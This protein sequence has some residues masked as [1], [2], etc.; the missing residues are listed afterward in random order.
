MDKKLWGGRFTEKTARSVE[1]FTSSISFDYR[2][3]HYDIQGSIAH[4]KML[5]KQKIIPADEAEKI[6]QALM[7]I[8]K[9]IEQSE[10]RFFLDRRRIFD[11]GWSEVGEI[12]CDNCSRIAHR[13]SRIAQ[14]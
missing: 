11:L 12:G 6:I 5:E 9:E 13:V 10:F 2:L 14:H 3:Y 1:E 7:E 8:E 4:C